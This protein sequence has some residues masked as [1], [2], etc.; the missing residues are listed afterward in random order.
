[1]AAQNNQITFNPSL[2]PPNQAALQA[3]LPASVTA[4]PTTSGGPTPTVAATTDAI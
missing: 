1:L 2:V 4:N 3:T